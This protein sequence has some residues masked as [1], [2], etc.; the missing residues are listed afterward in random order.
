MSRVLVTGGC[1]F[2][3]SAVVDVLLDRGSEVLIVDNLSNGTDHWSE[4][5]R[6]PRILIGDVLDLDTC[7]HAVREFRP[8]T[9]LHLAAHHY[10]PYCE[11]HPFEAYALNVQGT[12]HM[13][14]M[15]RQHGVRRFFLASTGDVYPPS[16]EPHR[17]IDPV[18]PVYVYGHTKML[19]EQLCTRY[20]ES[21]KAFET[22]LIGRLFNAAGAR[23][24][25]PHLLSDVA[26][27]IA[28]E[29]KTSIE[30]GNLWPLRD[31]IDVKSMA[32]AIVDATAA[33]EGLD[34]LNFGS[35]RAIEVR[36]A[37]NILISGLPFDVEVTSVA[38]RQ[39]PND[40]PFLCPDPSRLRR[41]IGRTAAA[42]D[43]GTA[44]DIFAQ[45]PGLRNA[46]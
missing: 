13:I 29:D 25:T 11:Q 40:R 41:L 17:E 31:Y 22:V 38:S 27:Q 21:S 18:A 43:L 33:V 35:G 45:Y 28:L 24:R 26:R 7:D 36:E 12:L 30:V 8:D 2:I 14:E 20:F 16:F 15:A 1:G 44:R 46:G 42:F 9:V 23:D 19:A 10:I 37:L 5:G 3:G 32:T 4:S 34:I 39:R 6:R